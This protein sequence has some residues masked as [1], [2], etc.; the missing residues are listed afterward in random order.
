VTFLKELSKNSK[1]KFC[2]ATFGLYFILFITLFF[3]GCSEDRD[4]ITPATGDSLPSVKEPLKA[5]H[6]IEYLT[7]E[8]RSA[9]MLAQKNH[10]DG[11][12]KSNCIQCH[13]TPSN[14]APEV[15]NNCH[16]KNGVNDEKDTCS[17]CHKVK[18][19]F[20]E[21]TSGNHQS[22]VTKGPK[23]IKCHPKV[24]PMVKLI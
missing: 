12:K 23:D 9:P 7:T 18:G 4:K 16:G 13:R 5:Y 10:P 19:E 6:P 22:H 3:L 8:V 2:F 24:M 1:N 15:C 21:P 14:I 11:W 20:G 17:N